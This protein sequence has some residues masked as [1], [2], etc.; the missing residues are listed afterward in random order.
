[1]KA[2]REAVI[3]SGARTPIGRFGGSFKDVSAAELG[4]I[5]IRAAV[6]RAGIDPATID[7]VYFGC[8]LSWNHDS[9]VARAST[10]AAGLPYEVPS[11]QVNRQCASG[12]EAIILAAQKIETGDAEIVVA[13]GTENMS[14]APFFVK[15]ARW[16]YRLGHDT[17]E[18]SLLAALHDPFTRLHMGGTAENIAERFGIS[19]EE[20]DKLALLSHQRAVAAIREGR[21]KEEIVPVTVP[22]PKGEPKI[23]DT[24]EHPRADTSL[25][26]LMKLPPVF[27]EG[28][29]VTAGNSAGI[30]DGAAA[31]VLMSRQKAEEL[32]IKPRLR[33]VSRAAAGVD[34]AIMG[35]GPIPAVR[36][37]LKMAGMTIKDIDLIEINEAFAAAAIYCMR[38][39]E[40]DIEK[41]NV[42]G[43]GISL[44]HPLGATGA[45]W[46]VKLM[47]EMARRKVKY[48]LVTF[49]C[50]GGQGLA[51]IFE[52]LFNI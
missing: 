32:G 13:G 8:V 19:R 1:M 25:E 16:G 17:F 26:K 2:L 10:I 29:T 51:A 47:Y 46:T 43:S 6:E 48:G 20:Q 4:G 11:T 44:G 27:K 22:Q 23:V 38:E 52:N 9:Y 41:T 45:M 15:R 21:F 24:D 31:L 28:G 12:L 49:C 30:N 39:L 42:N 18:D 3:V 14:Q 50:G 7:D 33:F 36:K 5:A 40:M 35:I 34:P 37:A